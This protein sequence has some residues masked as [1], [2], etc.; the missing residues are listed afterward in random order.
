MMGVK[1]PRV[2]SWSPSESK[3]LKKV[4]LELGLGGQVGEEYGKANRHKGREIMLKK[5][6]EMVK[7]QSFHL[8]RGL[9]L[10]ML[11]VY[12]RVTGG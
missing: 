6:E 4:K 5:K 1:W 8:H 3:V 2:L 9:N 10:S 12:I 11:F 7:M